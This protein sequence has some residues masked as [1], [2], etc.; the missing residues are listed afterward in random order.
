MN[1]NH[2][3]LI[4]ALVRPP[5]LQ[6]TAT[7][8]SVFE[9]TLSGER[10][11]TDEQGQL[12]M[13]PW[14]LR[15]FALG[16]LAEVLAKRRYQPGT[17]LYAPG[18]LDYSS[19]D[20]AEDGSKGSTT[21]VKLDQL[22]P[23][24]VPWEV[25]ALENGFRLKGGVNEAELS[26]NLTRDAV[27]RDTANGLLVRATIGVTTPRIGRESRPGYFDLKGWRDAAAPLAGLGKGA[28]LIVR[29]AVVT[30]QYADS[31]EAGRSRT[32]VYLDVQR[33]LLLAGR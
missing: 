20:K 7:G 2:V 22:E 19:F 18:C 23:I 29:G 15:A 33:A 28:G 27:R 14:Y 4:G 8:T 12:R 21:R 11:V 9:C 6:V 3:S 10:Q 5:Q 13:K 31:Q 32:A 16:R 26:G 24:Q 30:E 1:T 25:E 17:A